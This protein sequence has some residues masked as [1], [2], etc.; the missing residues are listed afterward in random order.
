MCSKNEA[1]KIL[2]EVYEQCKE[3]FGEL[4][5][6]YLY[7]SYARGDFHSESDVDILVSVRRTQEEISKSRMEIAEI[8]S[9]LSLKYDVTVSAAVKSA[10]QFEKYQNILPYY[11]NVIKEGIKYAG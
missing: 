8:A 9:S 3:L 4:E 7:G 2:N 11:M 6:A 1:L 10:E 5:A